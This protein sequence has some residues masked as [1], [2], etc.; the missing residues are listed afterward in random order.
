MPGDYNALLLQRMHLVKAAQCIISG[1][2]LTLCLYDINIMDY[3]GL[4][5]ANGT[6]GSTQV[7]F[8]FL[9][10][11]HVIGHFY[12]YYSWLLRCCH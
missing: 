5:I 2:V 10:N 12:F 4:V 3:G 7:V 9:L 8:D 11:L 6:V 1:L